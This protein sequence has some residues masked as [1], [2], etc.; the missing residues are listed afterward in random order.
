MIAVDVAIQSLDF[1]MSDLI[2]S[3]ILWLY[4]FSRNESFIFVHL[5]SCQITHK[6]SRLDLVEFEDCSNL[7]EK[8]LSLVQLNVVAALH[9]YISWSRSFMRFIK[10]LRMRQRV[11]MFLYDIDS[12]IFQYAR[13]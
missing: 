5:I 2:D 11:L 12:K 1:K 6:L 9:F 8:L 4:L 13:W 10:S 7:L 3:S